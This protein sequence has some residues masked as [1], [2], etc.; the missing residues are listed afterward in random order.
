MWL[1]RWLPRRGVVG[2][3]KPFFRRQASTAH[4]NPGKSMGIE[5]TT[6]A[7]I[8]AGRRNA[9]LKQFHRHTDGVPRESGRPGFGMVDESPRHLNGLVALRPTPRQAPQLDRLEP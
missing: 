4:S 6:I 2:L 8:F 9:A 5:K 7:T 1:P 3:V